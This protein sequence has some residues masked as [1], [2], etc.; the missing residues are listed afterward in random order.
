[1]NSNSFVSITCYQIGDWFYSRN[2][3]G[4]EPFSK[5]TAVYSQFLLVALKECNYIFKIIAL[6]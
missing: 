3:F 5:I 6:R 1:M 4:E 2:S